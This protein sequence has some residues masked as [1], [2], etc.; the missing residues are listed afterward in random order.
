MSSMATEPSSQATRAE[1]RFYPRAPIVEAILELQFPDA[2][3]ALESLKAF[4][5]QLEPN[6]PQCEDF[7]GFSAELTLGPQGIVT[8][9]TTQQVKGLQLKS[10]DSHRVVRL[11]PRS[12]SFHETRWYQGWTQFLSAAR[13]VLDQYLSAFP[14]QVISRIGLRYVNRID[15]PADDSTGDLRTWV[16]SAPDI[17]EGLPQYV[18]TYAVEMAM[19][20]PDI[21]GVAVMRQALLESDPRVLPRIVSILLDI[22]VFTIVPVSITDSWSKVD[23]LHERENLIFE[24]TITD[25]VRGIIS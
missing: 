18:S 21:K 11:M 4:S 17:P 22:D 14:R 19:P 13:P 6:Y 1:H 5:Q 12:I 20:Q 7:I 25:R 3:I 9:P 10:A 16:C 2:P 8:Q 24:R 23:V 15:I